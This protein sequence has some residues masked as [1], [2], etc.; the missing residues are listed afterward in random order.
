MGLYLHLSEP[1]FSNFSFFCV[2]LRVAE[3]CVFTA[4]SLRA[5]PGMAACGKNGRKFQHVRA[6]MDHFRPIDSCA[7]P[8]EARVWGQS[9]CQGGLKGGQHSP[10]IG[11]LWFYWHSNLGLFEAYFMGKVYYICVLIIPRQYFQILLH[12]PNIPDFSKVPRYM[13]PHLLWS[14]RS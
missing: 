2:L 10:L 4:C 6:R 7:P 12:I 13:P 9:P 8:A 14:W 5:T 1:K 3:C 11:K